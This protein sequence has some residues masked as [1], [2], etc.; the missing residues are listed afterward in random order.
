MVSYEELE[1]RSNVAQ[2][3]G[4]VLA[5]EMLETIKERDEEIERLR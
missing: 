3:I 5:K 2:V 4:D 1:R